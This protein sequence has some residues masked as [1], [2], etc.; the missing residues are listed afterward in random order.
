MTNDE[1]IETGRM[2]LTI[3]NMDNA[4]YSAALAA[5]PEM[6]WRPRMARYIKLTSLYLEPEA[7]AAV[8]EAAAR[9]QI[10]ASSFMRRAIVE[11]LRRDGYGRGKKTISPQG[12]SLSEK[13]A[14]A[15]A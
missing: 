10:S 13:E 9:E 5:N 8:M 14:T 11:R 4:A 2:W 15:A 6:F 12:K 1:I 3:W 7:H